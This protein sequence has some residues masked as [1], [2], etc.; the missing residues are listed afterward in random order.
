VSART[1]TITQAYRYAL[2]VTPAQ[3]QQ[4]LCFT[5][6]ARF[7]FNWGLALVKERLDA[8]QRGEDVFVPWS[9][10]SLYTEWQNVRD[11]VAPWRGE[12]P[13]SA[14]L[15]GLEGLGRAL[16]G[17]SR[18]R[19]GGRRAGF[20]RF[21]AKGR[22]RER[23]FFMHRDCRPL[24]GRRIKVP[25]LGAVR[26]AERLK[27]VNRLLQRDAQARI[28]RSTLVRQAPGRWSVSFTVE[29]S[30]KQRQAR[31][32]E[33]VVGIDLGL[34]RLATLS[35]GAHHSNPRPLRASVRRL[36]RLQ[37]RL[38]RQRRANNPVNF[39]PNGRVRRGPKN[40]QRSKRMLRT[41]EGIRRLHRRVANL[42]RESTHRLSTALTR[43][44]GVIGVESLNVAGMLRDRRL[45]RS[46][47]DAGLAE[48][49]RQLTYKASWAGGTLVAADRFYP[50]SKRCSRCGEVKAKLPRGDTIFTCKS[51][52]LSLDR[53]ENAAR[54][55]A[56]IALTA[57]QAE[58]RSTYLAPTGGERQNARRGQV[59]PRSDGA[60]HSPLKREGS[61]EG[62]SS[63]SR[64]GSALVSA[65]SH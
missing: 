17:F 21:R 38:D 31:H 56:Q 37:H 39:L 63:R 26:S 45:S 48:L 28:I 30:P 12:V 18:A 4:L 22:T 59:R 34:R 57:T 62:E 36:R 3:E 46:L 52:G 42:R 1:Q 40:W 27:E 60:G 23:I 53:D 32:P 61:P 14:F 65:V 2:R 51:C 15:T 7:A 25:K 41:E 16:Q 24:D 29:R 58:G 35:T 55:L 9:Y 50:S 64:E 33:A 6:A 43:E 13:Y 20:P 5:S 8:R 54:N 19:K 49:V 11:E 47:S 10:H 44:F